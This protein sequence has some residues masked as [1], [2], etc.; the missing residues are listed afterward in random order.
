M[1]YDTQG[2]RVVSHPST[3]PQEVEQLK[4]DNERLRAALREIYDLPAVRG[5]EAPTIARAALQKQ[6]GG[7]CPSAPRTA[8]QSGTKRSPKG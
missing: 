2:R 6:E 4:S 3:W 7:E 5:D 8:S 1:T